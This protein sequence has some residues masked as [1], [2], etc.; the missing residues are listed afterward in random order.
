MCRHVAYYR[1]STDRQGR[2]GLGLDAQREAVRVFLADKGWPPVAEFVEVESGKRKDRPEL[3]RAM[4]A[5][6][7]YKAT[8]VIAK[9]D[10]LARNVAFVSTLVVGSVTNRA[11]HASGSWD[12][13]CLLFKA[14]AA[15]RQRLSSSTPNHAV[16]VPHTVGRARF[17]GE[18]CADK[19]LTAIA[20]G[21]GCEFR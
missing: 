8:L 17:V 10:R 12:A 9:L 20:R 16:G 19:Y 2:S 21:G 3:E 4:E 11:W 14:A 5:C 18:S 13:G 1:V 15:R 7:L 6:R